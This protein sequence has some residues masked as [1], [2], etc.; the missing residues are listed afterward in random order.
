MSAIEEAVVADKR[1]TLA[2]QV[3]LACRGRCRRKRAMS[4]H[5]EE[6]ARI[7]VADNAVAPTPT[8]VRA[9]VSQTIGRQRRDSGQPPGNSSR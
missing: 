2:L 5:W 9:T 1:S 6:Y 3:E 4:R 7:L 8:V